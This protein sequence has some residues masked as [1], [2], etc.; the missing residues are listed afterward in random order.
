MKDERKNSIKRLGWIVLSIFIF[1][2]SPTSTYAQKSLKQLIEEEKAQ[3]AA[4][5]QAREAE[6]A[7]KEARERSKELRAKSQEDGQAITP[8]EAADFVTETDS[9]IWAPTHVKQLGV[10]NFGELVQPR[11]SI[12]L[13]D[14]DNVTTT[15]EY[16][17]ETGIYVLHTRI[18]DTDVTTPYMLTQEEYNHY[19]ERQ[20]MHQYWQQKVGEVEH[21]NEKKFDITD[22][23][24]NIGPADKVFG[25]GGVQLKMQGSAELLFGFIPKHDSSR[26]KLTTTIKGNFAPWSVCLNPSGSLAKG[27]WHFEPLTTSIYLNTVYGHEFWKS[28]PG[29][30]PDGYYEFMSTKFRLNLALGERM[31][32]KIP[33]EKLKYFSR[34][35]LFY[36]LSTCDLYIRSL[37]QG[38]GVKFTDIWGC[39][40]G[41]KFYTR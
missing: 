41:A 30:Y 3:K 11:S 16:Q 17:P 20:I 15:V 9:A 38:N 29:R 39:S 6:K 14:P 23:K 28:Q 18:G 5:K 13:Q 27:L 37:F 10:Q 22:M 40:I 19:A 2:F 4:E 36:E 32:L 8:E 33:K 31:T 25:P 21:N 12:D 1:H 7:A 35:S 24:F 26:P 34:I